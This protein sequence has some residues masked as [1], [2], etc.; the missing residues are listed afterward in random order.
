[1]GV[2]EGIS[3]ISSVSRNGLVVAG[4]DRGTSA[5]RSDARLDKCDLL[6][7]IS[8]GPVAAR[9]S[10][11]FHLLEKRALVPLESNLKNLA[12]F[13]EGHKVSLWGAVNTWFVLARG[14]KEHSK[15]RH[16][17]QLGGKHHGQTKNCHQG[18]GDKGR[19]QFESRD[20]CQLLR[21]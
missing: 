1:M 7:A 19:L 12:S 10:N 14:R 16:N 6:S 21:Q 15:Q 17:V 9:L 2:A 11:H 8:N 18:Q 4:G 3:G 20:L 5:S 13:I